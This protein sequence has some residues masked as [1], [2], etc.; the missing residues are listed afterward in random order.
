MHQPGHMIIRLLTLLGLLFF[1][2]KLHAIV[3]G[4]ETM[5]HLS[6]ADG[7]A[8]ETVYRVMT[9]HSG[10]TWI[11]TS[12]GLNIFDGVKLHEFPVTGEEGQKLEIYDLCEI[13][14]SRVYLA[15][16][17]GLYC[18]EKGSSHADHV[19]P[20]VKKPI[21]LMALGDTLFIGSQQGLMMYD[22]QRLRHHDVDVSHQGLSNIVR[23]Y[24]V[25]EKGR[26]WFLGRFDLNSY[27][28]QSDK[29]TRYKLPE[30]VCNQPL[31]QFTCL[32]NMRFLVGTRSNGLYL[33]DVKNNTAERVLGVGNI[34]STIQRSADGHICVGTD[35]T[36]AFLLDGKT[37][38]VKEHF[39]T[40]GDAL[41]RLLSNGIYCYY[42]DVNGVNWFGFVRYGLAYTYYSGSLF[43]G[44]KAGDFISE[45]I[46]VRTYCR[47]GDDVILGAQNGFYYVNAVT[48]AYRFFSPEDLGGGHI[49]NTVTWYEGRFYIGTFDGGLCVFD[50]V[51]MSVKR[52]SFTPELSS[53]SIG[54]VV[55]APDGRLWIGSG[56]G[57]FIV[58]DGQ[59]Q[60]HF[61]EQNS[62]IVG[63]LILG[64]TFDRNGN[65]WLTGAQGCS[66]YS[67]RSHEI[68]ET[69][70]PKG[71]FN[72]LPWMQGAAGHDG[73][74]FFRTGPKTFYTNED[75]T[76][77]GELKL[78]FT[79]TDKWCRG[80]VDDMNG[81]YLLASERGLFVFN[82]DLSG[83]I[84]FGDGEG[85]RGDFIND[86]GLDENGLLWVA[87][88]QGLYFTTNKK[89]NSWKRR[90]QFKAQ[91]INIR[92]GSDLMALKDAYIAN[93]THQIRLSWNIT[94][95]VLQVEVMLP[96]YAKQ[97]GRLYEYRICDEDWRIVDYGEP[98][99]VRGLMPGSHPLEVRLAGSEATT[100]VYTIT[101]VPSGWALFELILLIVAVVLLWLWWRFRKNTKVLLSERDE[102]EDAL[103]ESEELRVKSEELTVAMEESSSKYE[104]VRIDE[105]E[106]ADIVSRMEKYLEREKV[107]MNVDLKMKDLADVLHLSAPKLS[108]VFNL[109]LGQNYY[110]YINRYRLNEF[111]RLIEAGD[112]KRYTI[113]A[114]SEQCGFKKSNFFSTFRKVEGMTPTEY[115]KKKGIKI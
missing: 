63:G 12:N 67:V 103:I 94:S 16:D 111:K 50:P 73:L 31:T 22:G 74:V 62:R 5:G 82:Y 3:V 79:F 52:Q 113:T 47:H 2:S 60:Q 107:Y 46:N 26:I 38:E 42:R 78:P 71:F 81:H 24:A 55:A 88:S 35:G 104:R 18:V 96:D 36:G 86:M 68:V 106:C 91:L 28:P 101:V 37:L 90:L 83:M 29:I 114:L 53:T 72:Q 40:E 109:Y 7:L 100:S 76:D 95:D 84:H 97:T 21:S 27:E 11:A 49:V 75:M 85:L 110:D 92:V 102:I 87:T 69:T 65:A 59:V 23:Q 70:F 105:D 51:G 9:D 17:A 8:G 80:F 99:D 43:E 58:K 77:F 112:Y 115:L 32:G 33:C 89:Y 64:V 93:E 4:E 48:G 44:F 13:S 61:T 56:H 6:H 25:C 20:E 66:L 1:S 41:H 34:I 10:G 14:A 19:L 98:I 54:T 39:Y 15:T 57:L 108:Q 30:P 45:G